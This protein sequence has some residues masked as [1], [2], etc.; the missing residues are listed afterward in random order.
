MRRLLVLAIGVAVIAVASGCD[1]SSPSGPF[2]PRPTGRIYVPNQLDST[3]YIY[4]AATLTR[5]DSLFTVIAQPHFIQYSPDGKYFYLVGRVFA[6]ELQLAKFDLVADTFIAATSAPFSLFSTAI[7]IS[8]DGG[9]GYV[10]DFRTTGEAGR[11]YRF[12]L[13][14]MTFQDSLILSG[15][16]THDL[17]I[18][19]DGRFLVYP[20]FL[21]DNVT[22]HYLDTDST[23]FIDLGKPLTGQAEIG[24]FGVVLNST[25]SLAYVACRLSKEIRVVD[26][27]GRAVVDSFALPILG[28]TDKH[29]PALLVLTPDDQTLWFTTMAENKVMALEPATRRI[30]T[31]PVS[32]PRPFG[33]AIDDA[34]R[35]VYVAAVG[36][37]GDRGRVYVFDAVNLRKTDSLDVGRNSYGIGWFPR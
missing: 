19:S 27:A 29:G 22:V 24:G 16:G 6:P 5:E 14:T 20:N 10:C 3:L 8:P 33:I 25:D 18:S 35:F 13:N 12:D 7:Q 30:V 34:G 11:I 36:M 28:T 37:P 26:I 32:K 21:S 4:S 9:T 23:V 15:A 2:K 17:D 31:F 1:D